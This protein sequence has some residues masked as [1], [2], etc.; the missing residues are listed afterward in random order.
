MTNSTEEFRM[1][2]FI[3]LTKKHYKP[4]MVDESGPTN[5][6]INKGTWKSWFNRFFWIHEKNIKAISYI[7]YD[8]TKYSGFAFL[9][10]KSTRLQDNNLTF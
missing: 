7:N 8:W 6:G 4:V 2:D 3:D 9:N 1:N 5:G 10:W